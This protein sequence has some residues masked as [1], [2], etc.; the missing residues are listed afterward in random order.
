[1]IKT[2]KHDDNMAT[3][4][5]GYMSMNRMRAC[6]RNRYWTGAPGEASDGLRSRDSINPTM[7]KRS[8]GSKVQGFTIETDE[9]YVQRLISELAAGHAE[10]RS[11][12]LIA[13]QTKRTN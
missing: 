1:V 8:L 5:G 4:E 2:G 9:S 13:R 3:G 6:T 7:D 11:N 10:T 12:G